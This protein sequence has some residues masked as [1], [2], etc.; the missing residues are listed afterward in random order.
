MSLP[1]D[2]DERMEKDFTL[3][4]NN[5]ETLTLDTS[6]E[7]GILTINRPSKLNALNVQVHRELKNCLT[8]LHESK[9]TGLIVTGEGEKA[10]IAGADIAEM[11]PMSEGE[12]RAFSELGQQVSV[13][14]ETLPFP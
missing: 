1:A 4:T 2:S 8:E 11:K 12:A 14:F 6:G 10:F 3:M 9:L 13:L 5:F 7:V